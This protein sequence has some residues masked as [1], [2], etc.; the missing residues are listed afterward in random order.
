[1][2]LPNPQRPPGPTLLLLFLV[3]ILPAHPAAAQGLA[4]SRNAGGAVLFNLGYGVFS[5][6][7]DLADRFG[8]GFALDGGLD[9]LPAGKNWQFGLMGR[10]GFGNEVREDVLAGLRLNNG[11]IIS[12]Q[13]SPADVQL[14]HRHLFLGARAGYTLALGRK[15]P[16]AGLKLSTGLG[17]LS[18]WIRVQRDVSQ[19]V[20]QV[21]GFR[22]AGYDRLTGGPALYQFLGY[23]QLAL[24]RRLN[25][26]AGVE[27]LLGLTRARRAFD[28][29]TAA[30]SPAD[31]RTDLIL[32]ARLG[33]ILPFYRGEG[34]EIFY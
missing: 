1:M 34:R 13:R 6:A 17:W 11:T 22:R 10:F 32:G 16:R 25:F 30:P 19:E 33:I 18:H 20:I 21:E 14:R 8:G 29:A 15:N 26:Y 9:Y 4:G 2:T 31:G 24:D 28:V 5:P 27:A 23:Q 3:L 12:N 7:G